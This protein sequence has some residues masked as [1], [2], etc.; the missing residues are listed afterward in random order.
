MEDNFQFWVWSTST[1]SIFEDPLHDWR[2]FF[3]AINQT[4][5]CLSHSLL[6]AQLIDQALL[7]STGEAMQRV[8]V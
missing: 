6:A 1:P 4:P 2:D 3:V 5:D 8:H 7:L